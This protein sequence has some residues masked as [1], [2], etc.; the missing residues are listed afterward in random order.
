MFTG[1]HTN[2]VLCQE[3]ES[4]VKYAGGKLGRSTDLIKEGKEDE[5][6]TFTV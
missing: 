2:T 1:F 4:L 6:D 5:R 3:C